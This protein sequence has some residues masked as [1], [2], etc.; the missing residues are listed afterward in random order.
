[1]RFALR[2]D[3]EAHFFD[4]PRGRGKLSWGGSVKLP[5]DSLR[6]AGVTRLD[7]PGPSSGKTN[8]GHEVGGGGLPNGPY[9]K[10]RFGFA[11]FALGVLFLF[12]VWAC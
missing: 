3:I 10:N 5:G 11:G 8:A 1:M 7:A 2:G 6:A 9:W 12:N 4:A